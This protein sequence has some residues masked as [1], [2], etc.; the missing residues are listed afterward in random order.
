MPLLEA[1]PRDSSSFSDSSGVW[2]HGQRSG[3]DQKDIQVPW[4]NV[5]MAEWSGHFPEGPSESRKGCPAP[6]SA[7]GW[8]LPCCHARQGY[9]TQAIGRSMLDMLFAKSPWKLLC[10]TSVITVAHFNTLK[11]FLLALT[12]WQAASCST[13]ISW[14]P[15]LLSK[16]SRQA[17]HLCCLCPFV[18]WYWQ[19]N[20]SIID[21]SRY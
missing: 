11:P 12:T 16:I 1:F 14:T 20:L 15:F 7:P 5:C 18:A 19:K 2:E 4:R 13:D 21:T 8:I 10:A 17:W 3:E 9:Q 6:S